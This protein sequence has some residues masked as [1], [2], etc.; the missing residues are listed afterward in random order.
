MHS[1]DERFRVLTH[2]NHSARRGLGNW[3]TE[4]S[5][6]TRFPAERRKAIRYRLI[7]PAVFS[8]ESSEHDRFQ[9]EGSTREIS[10]IG[11]YILTP[12]TPPV[13]APVNVEIMISTLFGPIKVKIKGQMR[14]QRVK[15]AVAENE[16]G[17]FSVVG[18]WNEL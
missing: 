14:V 5:R 3:G 9:G 11:A 13:D 2:G 1:N 15:H 16:Q 8:W 18:E 6:A 17:G 7:V 10:A 12:T 4:I